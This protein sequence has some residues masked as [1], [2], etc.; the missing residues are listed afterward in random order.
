M[1]RFKKNTFLLFFL[2]TSLLFLGAGDSYDRAVEAYRL[3]RF[4]D[5][6]AALLAAMEEEPGQDRVHLLLG[7]VYQKTSRFD[8]AEES[9]LAGADMGGG[10]RDNLLFNLANLYYAQG[11][12][13]EAV[14]LYTDIVGGYSD[15][16][17]GALLNRANC[18]LSLGDFPRARD[19]YSLYLEWEP[20][21]EQRDQIEQMI[22][23]LNRKIADEEERLRLA[24]QQKALE[25]QR[26][27]E[28]EKKAAEEAA[29]QQAL[30][31]EILASLEEVSD[32]TQ[33]MSAESETIEIEDEYSDIEE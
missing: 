2:G 22:A 7:V 33:V 23:L 8:K 12:K 6:E 14:S 29:R 9:Y 5:A 24:A 19:D 25:E 11:R 16:K 3:S 13:D 1:N 10:S 15:F 17:A 21:A 20:Q 28:A 30:L 27:L 18:H 31:D 4:D 26:R 32:E